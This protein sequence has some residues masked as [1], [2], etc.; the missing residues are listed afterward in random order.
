MIDFISNQDQLG[1]II[2][3]SDEEQSRQV[4]EMMKV[5]L[6]DLFEEA[7]INE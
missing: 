6:P 5:E 1:A 2:K 3:L 4:L 7:V